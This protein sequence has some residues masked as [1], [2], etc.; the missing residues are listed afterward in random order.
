MPKRT[1]RSTIDYQ[2]PQQYLL[3]FEGPSFVSF[4][5]GCRGGKTH[6]SVSDWG[7]QQEAYRQTG[8]VRTT[9]TRSDAPD[10]YREWPRMVSEEVDRWVTQQLGQQVVERTTPT[11]SARRAMEMGRVM[12]MSP[13]MTGR[14]SSSTSNIHDCGSVLARWE[15]DFE[16]RS[17]LTQAQEAQRQTYRRMFE[18]VQY[19]GTYW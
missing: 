1:T 17:V 2:H 9:P 14:L 6:M 10:S 15:R 12:G 19:F 7:V 16:R 8:G 11:R 4:T 13:T 18:G 5:A 3:P